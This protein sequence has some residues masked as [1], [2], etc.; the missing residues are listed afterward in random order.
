MTKV[1]KGGT[2]CTADSAWNDDVLIDLTS[3]KFAL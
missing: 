3:T 2:D 1:I